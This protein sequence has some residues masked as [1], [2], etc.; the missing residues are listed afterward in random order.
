MNLLPAALKGFAVLARHTTDLA[1]GT[2][3]AYVVDDWP[4]PSFSP[5]IHLGAHPPHE[6]DLDAVRGYWND[7]WGPALPPCLLIPVTGPHPA[8]LPG[9]WQPDP[10]P[11]HVIVETPGPAVVTVPE[12]F[13][14][15]ITP[16]GD[17]A[18]EAAFLDL[19]TTCFP[20]TRTAPRLVLE[21]LRQ[22]DAQTELVTLTRR[23]PPGLA[24]TSA[25]SVKDGTCFQTW[26]AVPEPYRGLRLSRTLQQAAAQ[27]C[28]DLG[29]S[30]NVTVTRNPRVIGPTR[31]RVDLWIYRAAA[32]AEAGR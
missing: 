23:T 7:Q 1:G 19:V 13:N 10:R 22:A 14:L 18:N 9:G 8:P 17:P 32:D 26:G 27:R 6:D 16:M 20:D 2:F 21:Q 4:A 24:A 11:L 25:L 15:A 29:A 5:I 30:R 31:P 28:L 3:R 12:G